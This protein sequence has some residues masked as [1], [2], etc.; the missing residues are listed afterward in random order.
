MSEKLQ[1]VVDSITTI[2]VI[3]IICVTSSTVVLTLA[4]TDVGALCPKLSEVSDE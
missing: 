1:A 3:T 4:Q 2:I